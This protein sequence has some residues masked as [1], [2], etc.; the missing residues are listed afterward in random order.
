MKKTSLPELIVD[1][2]MVGIVLMAAAFVAFLLIDMYDATHPVNKPL[3]ACIEEDG[4]TQKECIWD[5]GT[6]LIVHNWDWGK[7]SDSWART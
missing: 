5:D 4:S 3:P 7:S 2:L 1:A 6:G